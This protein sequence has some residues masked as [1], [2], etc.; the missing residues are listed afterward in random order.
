MIM[1]E[2]IS[3]AEVAYGL[4]L[5]GVSP[6]E[7]AE[8]LG[9]GIRHA[10]RLIAQKEP[11]NP[12]KKKKVK[13]D[14]SGMSKK[15]NSRKK[16]TAPKTPTKTPEPVVEQLPAYIREVMQIQSAFTNSKLLCSVKDAIM[17]REESRRL[18]SRP[19]IPVW[20][21][22]KLVAQTPRQ[23]EIID[24]ICDP[25]IGIVMIEGDKRTGKSTSTFVGICQGV[26]EGKFNKIGLWAAGRDNAKGILKDVFN[27]KITYTETYPLFKGFGSTQ[28]KLFWNGAVLCAL[29][30]NDKSTSGL[31]FDCCWI[32][33]CH[34]VVENFPDVFDMIVMTMRAKPN[35]KLILSMNRGTGVYE[36]FKTTLLRDLDPSEYRFF[37]LT[38]DDVSHITEEADTK[39]RTIVRAVGGADSE[40]R[41]LDNAEVRTGSS[42]NPVSIKAAYD[43]YDVFISFNK[44]EGVFRVLSFDPS[45]SGHPMGW[46]CGACNLDGT[47]FWE[48]G[49]G[50]LRLADDLTDIES[51]MGLTPEQIRLIL[52]NH[53]R[54]HRITLFI[55]ESNMNGKEMVIFFQQHG[56]QAINQNFAGPN[57]KTGVSRGRM[58][59]IVREIMDNRALYLKGAE[60]KSNLLIY[61]PDEHEK[62]AK[63]KGDVSDAFIHCIYR[64]AYLSRSKYLML[65][66]T[67]YSFI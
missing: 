24:A 46:F 19:D 63:F 13:N 40:R 28:Q 48:L 22:P 36:L 50:E 32:D 23:M 9:C 60:L 52:L 64:L 34:A 6:K 29:S 15:S 18:E 43:Q 26:W 62:S 44:T 35:I 58:I 59:H 66:R 56:F 65:G 38:K 3:K 37:T 42:F 12:R 11:I 39:V 2:K 67:E 4:Y 17:L 49:S 1:P 5:Q 33:E 30:T 61:N 54:N 53:A 47:E 16:K 55:S 25:A 57:S 45:G 7:I 41:W 14:D 20:N 21:I 10:Y 8:R 31:D 51:A 27:D